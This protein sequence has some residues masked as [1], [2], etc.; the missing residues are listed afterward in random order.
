MLR[1][2]PN[3]TMSMKYSVSSSFMPQALARV[4]ALTMERG[5]LPSRIRLKK[6]DPERPALSWMARNESPSFCNVSKTFFK[7]SR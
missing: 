7:Y 4:F 2:L 6:A 3:F 1:S 5:R